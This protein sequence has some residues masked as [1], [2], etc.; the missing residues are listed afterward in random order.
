MAIEIFGRTIKKIWVVIQVWWIGI[1]TLVKVRSV[2][3]MLRLWEMDN[4]HSRDV[5]VKM[6]SFRVLQILVLISII[7][8]RYHPDLR[9]F[10]LRIIRVHVAFVLPRPII[11]L[12]K[13]IGSPET[14]SRDPRAPLE[15]IVLT[16]R[17]TTG[18][19]FAGYTR[20]KALLL[21]GQDYQLS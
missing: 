19:L 16:W 14:L 15:S 8:C 20:S 4:T 11:P 10:S 12:F 3:P 21:P 2:D 13:P 5:V 1:E 18:K 9:D 7:R 6:R 17:N